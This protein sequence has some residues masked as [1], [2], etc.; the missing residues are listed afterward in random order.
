[1][2][3]E[4]Y[5]LYANGSD[6]F[7]VYG[8]YGCNGEANLNVELVKVFRERSFGNDYYEN[9]RYE[10]KK[11]GGDWTW[12]IAVILAAPFLIGLFIIISI[13]VVI[14]IAVL[15]ISSVRRHKKTMDSNNP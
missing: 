7:F 2:D 6:E 9:D 4:E 12:L 3:N 11:T 10:S 5:Y 14:A 15:I 1:M 13:S 8:N